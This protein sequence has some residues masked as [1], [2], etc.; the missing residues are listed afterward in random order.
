MPASTILDKEQSFYLDRSKGLTSQQVTFSVWFDLPPATATVSGYLALLTRQHAYGMY[1]KKNDKN[2]YVLLCYEF[3]KRGDVLPYEFPV[4][5]TS[6]YHAVFTL[7]GTNANLYVNGVKNTGITDFVVKNLEGQTYIGGSDSYDFVVKKRDETLQKYNGT[8]HRATIFNRCLSEN[9]VTA[10]HGKGREQSIENLIGTGQAIDHKETQIT[11]TN[12]LVNP[13]KLFDVAATYAVWFRKPVNNPSGKQSL[14]NRSGFFE[15]LL[16]GDQLQAN[17]LPGDTFATTAV[18]DNNWHH[19]VVTI[20][21]TTGILYLDGNKIAWNSVIKPAEPNGVTQISQGGMGEISRVT[22]FDRCLS[23][24]EVARL[25]RRKMDTTVMDLR[26]TGQLWDYQAAQLPKNSSGKTLSLTVPATPPVLVSPPAYVPTVYP[27]EISLTNQK[28]NTSPAL[29]IVSDVARTTDVQKIDITIKN[30][31]S[32][33]YQFDSFTLSFR[34][35]TLHED[36]TKEIEAVKAQIFCT[37]LKTALGPNAVVKVTEDHDN[38]NFLV[39][40]STTEKFPLASQS[41]LT[42]SLAGVYAAPGT[43]TRTSGYE[44]KF[45]GVQKMVGT[46]PSGS[47]FTFGRNAVLQII[48]HQGVSYAPVH[49]GVLGNNFLLN[50]NPDNGVKYPGAQA[51]TIFM[52]SLDGKAL[53]I[54]DNTQFT[55]TFYSSEKRNGTSTGKDGSIPF[56]NRSEV[57]GITVDNL[58][59][60]YSLETPTSS[61]DEYGKRDIIIKSTAVLEGSFVAFP[62]NN[63]QLS[64]TPGIIKVHVTVENLP[65]YWDSKFEVPFVKGPIVMQKDQVGINMQASG[66]NKLSIKGNSYIDGN[67]GINMQPS[68]GNELSIKGDTLLDGSLQIKEKN[69]LK[70]GYGEINKEASAGAMGYNIFSDALDIVGAGDK[71]ELRKIKFWAEGGAKFTGTV[72]VEGRIK[73]KTG[74]VMPVGSIIAYGGEEAPK[75]WLLCNGQSLTD[76]EDNEK[77]NHLYEELSNVLGKAKNVPDLSGRFILGVGE[78]TDLNKQTRSFTLNE[79]D[80]G[81]VHWLDESEMP[82]HRHYSVGEG[83]RDF[84]NEFLENKGSQNRGIVN[85]DNYLYGTTLTGGDQPHNNMPPYYVLTYIIKY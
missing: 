69:I 30:T 48:N 4:T 70:F 27:F 1:V 18:T 22:I 56:G 41:T 81:Y 34:K 7:D 46:T 39:K 28:D 13:I 57:N 79:S 45:Q 32:D 10:L 49:F 73:D 2:K 71:Y 11:R 66:T 31:T 19:G 43:G 68:T 44:V 62:F 55:F 53:K 9:E 77:I 61:V 20:Q 64:G 52:Q 83:Q 85:N 6:P 51:F 84:P 15:L 24:S 80:G 47:A 25:Y 75:G 26:S 8:I 42:L 17:C 36:L 76:K 12:G 78:G 14:V 63:I 23:A 59:S 5:G 21:G 65:G 82:S 74:E 29:Y 35:G 40:K 37:L 50:N 38:I 3:N 16:L 54:A 72:N 67:V 33:T 58:V 60:G